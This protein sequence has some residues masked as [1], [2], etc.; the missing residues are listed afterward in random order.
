MCEY[1]CKGNCY[2]VV[3]YSQ[4]KKKDAG[5]YIRIACCNGEEKHCDF[6]KIKQKKKKT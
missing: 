2:K 3:E 6:N 5:Q 4:A 1:F